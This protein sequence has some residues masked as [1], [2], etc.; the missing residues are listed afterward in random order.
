MIKKSVILTQF[1]NPGA[2]VTNKFYVVIQIWRE[3][4]SVSGQFLVIISL[5]I[6]PHGNP[7]AHFCIKQFIRVGMKVKQNF[8]WIRILMEKS[9]VKWAQV[10]PIRTLSNNLHLR[11]NSGGSVLFHLLNWTYTIIY[12]WEMPGNIWIY[13]SGTAQFINSIASFLH[14]TV[15]PLA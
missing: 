4:H 14:N 7:W 12:P 15:K 2:H 6:L 8:P 9:L 5:S 13:S 11:S 10:V 1:F 3:F